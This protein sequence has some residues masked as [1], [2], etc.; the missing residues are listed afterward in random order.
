MALAPN[1][2]VVELSDRDRRLLESVARSLQIAFP[3]EN[4]GQGTEALK[5]KP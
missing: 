4:V 2:V 5:K 1:K 3:E